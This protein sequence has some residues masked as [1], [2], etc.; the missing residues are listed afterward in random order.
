MTN[1]ECLNKALEYT[2]ITN[3]CCAKVDRCIFT[4]HCYCFG[5]ISE[6]EEYKVFKR[7]KNA[8]ER[9]PVRHGHWNGIEMDSRGYTDIFECSECKCYVRT[10]F[11]MKVMEYD[12]CPSCGAKMDAQE[13]EN[14]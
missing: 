10:P 1:E 7:I 12:F 5:E 4:N 11:M 8:L 9:E 6:C 13:K 14:E 2:G 3:N